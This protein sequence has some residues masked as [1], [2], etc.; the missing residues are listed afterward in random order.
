MK[1][2]PGFCMFCDQ[3]LIDGGRLNGH[4]SE[5]EVQWSNGSKMKIGICKDD[6]EKHAWTTEEGK[7]II[8]DW[9]H[10]YWKN[11]GA[12]MDEKIVIV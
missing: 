1:Y 2:T 4:Y 5:V 10:T 11:Q 9:H 7:K 3:S 8:T 6:A 12:T